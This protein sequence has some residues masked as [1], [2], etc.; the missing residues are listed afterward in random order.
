MDGTIG[1]DL[2]DLQ[3]DM[4]AYGE[5]NGKE[6]TV[7]VN[8]GDQ[9]QKQTMALDEEGQ[10]GELLNLDQFMEGKDLQLPKRRKRKTAE[11]SM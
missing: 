3:L 6:T 4:D 11:K 7:Y 8:V 10:T 5:T 1:M 2:M 9:W